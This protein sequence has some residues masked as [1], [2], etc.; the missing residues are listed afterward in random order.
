MKLLAIS[1]DTECDK[2]KRWEIIKP[3][4]FRGIY[5]GVAEYLQPLF[6][7]YN[8]KPTYLLSPEVILDERSVKIF[9]DIN[10]R[11]AE[12]GTHLH[13]EFIEPFAN[14]DADKTEEKAEDYTDEVEFEKLKNLTVLFK[15]TFKFP[16]RSYRA[17][18]YSIR[19]RTFRFLE[20]L[21]YRVDTS[22]SPF[23]F[24]HPPIF[25]KPYKVGKILE[26][27]ITSYPLNWKF[28]KILRSLPL[29]KL[30]RFRNW[31]KRF[32]PIW[33]RPSL[34]DERTMLKLVEKIEGRSKV[35][36]LNLFMHNMEVVENLSP[37]DAEFTRKNLEG[38]IP[39]LVDRGYRGATLY[40][41][42]EAY[43]SGKVPFE[44]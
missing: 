42:Y 34:F 2:G 11:G 41:I 23:S 5:W 28:F 10:K 36:I 39:K 44:G 1:I 43:E 24:G 27:P 17:G 31:A 32:G 19:E 40:E 38:I 13:G 8:L 20:A 18:R 30:R 4:G 21:D 7:R 26:V 15:E 6:E 3:M 37:Y 25:P 14:F 12:L 22:V 16:P 9:I 35:V 33:L 29:Y